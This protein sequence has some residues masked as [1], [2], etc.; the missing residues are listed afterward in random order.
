MTPSEQIDRFL[1]WCR[2][3]FWTEILYQRFIEHDEN[4]YTDSSVTESLTFALSAHWLSS[5]YV[6]VEG[7][8]CASFSDDVIDELLSTYPDFV[9]LLKRFRN[10][11]FHYQT[12]TFDDRLTAFVQNGSETLLWAFA[13][14]YEFKRFY[15]QYP[16]RTLDDAGEKRE[17]REALH[18]IVGWTPTDILHA[19]VA[20]LDDL[21]ANAAETLREADDFTSVEAKAL[22]EAVWDMEVISDTIECSPLLKQLPRLSDARQEH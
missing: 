4:Q 8:E 9:A 3:L 1:S 7:W 20:E 2:Y 22:I 13:L 18:H 14:F 19:K 10:G 6:V 5:L 11:V 17:L 15:W 21:G 12:K 16:D